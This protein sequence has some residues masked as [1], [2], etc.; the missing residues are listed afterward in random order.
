V[1]QEG[2]LIIDEDSGEVEMTC[3]IAALCDESRTIVCASDRA[4]SNG[5][6]E[7]EPKVSKILILH[8]SWRL[9]YAGREI[10]P[11]FDIV[12][13]ARQGL[14]DGK[15]FTLQQISSVVERAY[16]QVIPNPIQNQLY[17]LL[18]GFDASGK[19]YISSIAP[20]NPIKAM[21]RDSPGYWSIGSGH[22]GAFY[23]MDYRQVSYANSL[24]HMVYY[25]FEGKYSGELAPGV[26]KNKTDLFIWRAGLKPLAVG[27]RSKERLE[28]IA[29]RSQPR[30]FEQ[31]Y[32]KQVEELPE[33]VKITKKRQLRNGS[34]AIAHIS[35][36]RAK[37]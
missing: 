7:S 25:V 30:T 35:S 15:Q 23:M 11:V 14:G 33:V 13:Q 17:L 8:P 26:G 28:D 12:D 37:S 27:K 20:T 9:M 16:T 18:F 31:K 6:I 3:C 29:Y 32:H 24:A 36:K 22:I 2:W 34:P 1:L 21:R 4:I 19:G 5:I 10:S